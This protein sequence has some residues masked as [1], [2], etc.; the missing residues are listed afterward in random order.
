MDTCADVYGQILSEFSLTFYDLKKNFL[1]IN[2][3]NVLLPFVII[4][5]LSYL[6]YQSIL[7]KV[8]HS[9]KVVI[10]RLV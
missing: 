5:I 4:F 6:F 9:I 8:L 1:F 10:L 7:S 2:I 3:I